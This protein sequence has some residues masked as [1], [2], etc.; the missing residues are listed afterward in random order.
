MSVNVKLIERDLREAA[1]TMAEVPR[2][3]EQIVLGDHTVVE[4]K[5]VTWT[6][7]SDT[8]D[9]SVWVE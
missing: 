2:V 7:Y 6:P 3:G 9:A 8:F 5:R 4:V 1:V